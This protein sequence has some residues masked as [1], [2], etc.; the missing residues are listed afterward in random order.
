MNKKLFL[1]VFAA[2]GILLAT[3]CQNDELDAVQTG[4]EATVSF[5]LGVEGGV[6]TRAI[7]D[8]LTANR[9]V[10]AVFDEEGNRITTIAKVD[11]DANFPTTEN[12]TLAKGQ[13]YKVAFWAQNSA[14]SAYVLD[15]DM[16]L[17][18]DYT[19]S[20]NNDEER[21][22]FFKTETF[23]V[24]GNAQ[25]DVVLKRPFAQ[26]NLGVTDTDWDAAV[27][28]GIEIATSK[29]VIK[30]AFTNMDLI[31]GSVS[32][33]TEVVYD[34]GATPKSS[35]EVLKVDLD[36]DGTAEEYHYLSMSYILVDAQKS[37]LQD[38]DFTFHP[39]SGND[40]VFG[41]GLNNVP[42]QRNWRTNIIGQI[43][44]GKIDFNISIDPIY[45]EEYNND[46]AVPVELNGVYYSTIEGALANATDGDVINLGVSNYTLPNNIRL[47]DGVTGTITFVGE[48]EKTVINGSANASGIKVIMKDLTW[49][50]P[51]NGYDTAFTHA[52]SV[53]FENCNITGQYYAQSCAPHTFISCTIDPQTGYLYTYAS[54]CTFE[55]CTFKSSKGKAL[56]V[57]NDGN[58][59]TFTVNI[60]NC[61]FTAD[62][63]ANTS[64]GKPVTAIDINSIGSTFIVNI[65]NTTATGYGVGEYSGSTLWNIKGGQE[66]VTVNIDGK[67]ANDAVEMNGAKYGTIAAALANVT[68]GQAVEIALAEGTYALPSAAKGKNLTFV[69]TGNAANTIIECKNDGYDKLN[70]STV[71]F[72]NLT[73]ETDN[74]TYRGFIH[75]SGATYKNCIIKNQLTLY[76]NGNPLLFDNCTFHAS[77]NNY[78]VWTWGTS[79]TFK[80][81]TFNCNGKAMLVYGSGTS[82]VTFTNCIFNDFGG[83]N[84]KAAI[85]TGNDY[86]ATYTININN[87]KVNG[88]DVNSV[89]GS[90]VWGNKNSMAA[91]KLNVI[92]DNVDVY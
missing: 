2:A 38:L 14:T 26:M 46:T 70:G 42:V 89:S 45:D 7:S 56:Q 71:T 61:T 13:T 40:I 1:G 6:Q 8:G 29:V 66:K 25:I 41:E 44:T 4:N 59:G 21:D 73:I 31:D 68:S 64:A 49:K 86:D 30:N 33:E 10:Y 52:T 47:K 28:S 82:E 43:L 27:A 18:I 74:E 35:N 50:S 36:A 53:S 39:I 77:G 87:C 51:N 20:A 69:G 55:N 48:G 57:Y 23:T 79:A 9:L 88:F 60:N 22:A 92:I 32:G 65:N 78:N 58:E 62:Q 3:S 24:T 11:K 75:V 76:S 85:E 16:N 80:D 12:I 83:Q 81:C 72:K 90:N 37:T 54:N 19:N 34:F 15:D 17:T 63:T 84:G 67:K 5:T 91:D